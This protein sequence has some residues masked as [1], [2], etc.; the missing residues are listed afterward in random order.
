[1]FISMNWI[2]DFVDLSGIDLKNL[3]NR[4][5]L[6]TAEVEDIYEFGG[7]TENVVVGKILSVENHPN[8]KKLHLL[9]VDNGEGVV[10]VVCGAPNV[11]EGAL[12]AFAK[13][14]GMVKGTPINV[15]EVAG[16][17]SYGMCCSEKELGISEDNSGIIKFDMD[18]TVGTDIKTFI[19]LDDTV[20]EVDNKSLTNRP[21]LWGHYGIAREIAAL[22][23]RPLKKPAVLDAVNYENLPAVDIKVETD[24]CYR[25]SSITVENVQTR[26]SPYFM[27]VRLMYCGQRPINLLA[28]LTNY[29]MLEF[30]QPMHAFDN[31]KV[32]AIRVKQLT[33]TTKFTTLDSQERDVDAGTI[34]IFNENEPVAIAGIMG[35]LLSEITDNTTSL[36]LESANFEGVSVRRSA[37]KLGMRTDASARYEKTLDPE[38][39]DTAI[40]RFLKL[41]TDIDGDVKVTSRLSDVYNKHFDKVSL[42]FDK[43]YI[44]KYTGI[45]ITADRI[46]ETL[47]DLEFAVTRDGDSF[48][49][50]VPSFRAT[51]DIT[52]KADI[53]EEITRIYGYDNFDIRSTSTMLT[54][55]R[56]DQAREDEYRIKKLLADHFKYS[57]VHSYIWYDNKCNKELGID[58]KSY[59]RIANSLTGDNEE[60]RSTMLPTLLAFVRKNIDSYNNVRIFE[61]GRCVRGLKEDGNVDE[62]KKLAFINASRVKDENSLLREVKNTLDCISSEVMN[63]EPLYERGEIA[64][65]WV[66]PKNSANILVDGVNVGYISVLNPRV[67]AAI[68]RKLSAAYVEIDYEAYAKSQHKDVDFADVSRFPGVYIDL[69]LLV[70]RN[71]PF[72]TIRD[73]VMTTECEFLRSVEFVDLFKGPGLVND[74]ASMTIRLNFLSFERTLS[75]EE[76]NGFVKNVLDNLNTKG[77][78][79]RQ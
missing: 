54:P 8:S 26:V 17:T 61:F 13:A 67:A 16:Y 37:T 41:L 3:I 12:V 14:G 34:M 55:I 5:T 53:V 48:K 27:K 6:A 18:Y 15:A 47:K 65:S 51:K 56:Q 62:V 39:T 28:D 11:E 49:V 38:M 4:F 45:D 20:F 10:D 22:V 74:L 46:E 58:P 72:S 21:D 36:L 32:K 1:M 66:H 59:V 75:V 57:E 70:N 44:D 77:I 60:I 63:Q 19:P 33:E 71:T 42:E 64:L 73:Y 9:K 24:L 35:G 43:A 52:M 40:M 69:S 30:G 68:D 23:K 25:Y 76:V 7:D 50:D 79:M 29:L 2:S 78:S 31:E